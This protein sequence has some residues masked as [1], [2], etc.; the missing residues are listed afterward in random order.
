MR[1]SAANKLTRTGLQEL[2]W[3]IARAGDERGRSIYKQVA[4]KDGL[5]ELVSEVSQWQRGEREA[6]PRANREGDHDGP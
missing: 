5:G 2:F 4:E 1:S 6:K 3:F